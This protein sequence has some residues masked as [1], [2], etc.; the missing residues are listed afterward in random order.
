M[1]EPAVTD[2]AVG[3]A[4]NEEF[5][6]VA[7]A[8]GGG[9]GGSS[10]TVSNASRWRRT[11]VYELEIKLLRDATGAQQPITS[12]DIVTADVTAEELSG[13]GLTKAELNINATTPGAAAL[14]LAV[15]RGGPMA[16]ASGTLQGDERL[17]RRAEQEV[18]LPCGYA[19]SAPLEQF[20]LQLYRE[21]PGADQE[22]GNVFFEKVRSDG[23]AAPKRKSFVYRGRESHMGALV[24]D[25]KLLVQEKLAG[26]SNVPPAD[27]LALCV[28]TLDR[29][30]RSLRVLQFLCQPL[31]CAV[32]H[33]LCA[34]EC[35]CGRTRPP[36]V[37]AVANITHQQRLTTAPLPP[38]V[39][40][41][42]PL[43][44]CSSPRCWLCARAC[45]PVARLAGAAMR[46]PAEQHVDERARRQW[47]K[48]YGRWDVYIWNVQ[49]ALVRLPPSRAVVFQG[50]ALPRDVLGKFLD[51]Y[52]PGAVVVWP[53][54]STVSSNP[55]VHKDFLKDDASGVIFK[56]WARKSAK[57]ISPFSNFPEEE[58]LA[59]PMNTRFRVLDIFP[60]T[61]FN[62]LANVETTS[63]YIANP[64]STEYLLP[65]PFPSIEAAK[66]ASK[67]L[68]MLEVLNE[69][70]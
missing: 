53:S 31:V 45:S 7:A 34:F 58:L 5:A 1:D 62:L 13:R 65:D 25:A 55:M 8:G 49:R 6:E 46:G 39:C 12:V 63:G 60:P 48:D 9:G 38:P 36:S 32:P 16:A 11:V 57:D 29:W 20:L 4:E 21:E 37:L 26:G 19:P 40:C 15:G 70:Q 17:L 30:V 69:E 41:R 28:L 50:C 43:L 56:I 23:A 52:T 42:P 22:D 68:I 10:D 54:F 59:L 67:V 61:D 51:V 35:R 66:K 44:L 3:L 64:V 2:I 14:F 33:Q 18:S 47:E 27:I 24:R